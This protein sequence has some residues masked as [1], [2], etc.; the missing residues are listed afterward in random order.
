[1]PQSAPF[2]RTNVLGVPVA[3]CSVEAVAQQV[4]DW[5]GSLPSDFGVRYV[6]ATS[7]HGV[8]EAQ[9]D[10]GFMGILSR[11]SIVTPDG[12]P[13]AWMGRLQGFMGMRRVYGPDVMLEVCRLAAGRGLRH[14][15]YGGAPGVADALARR[16]C[17]QF[18]GLTVAGT[19]CPPFRELSDH[20][21]SRVAESI[22]SASTDILWVGLSTPKQERW[23][24]RIQKLLSVKVALTVGAAFDF[25]TGRVPQAPPWMQSRGLE[26]LYRVLREPRRLWRRYAYNN[27]RFLWL[28]LLQLAGLRKDTIVGD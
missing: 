19:Y 4:V 6:C 2:P 26:W 27:P 5:A 8:I 23:I 16:M 7:V 17:E 18:P 12:M 9:R 1:M 3:V 22:N 11:A 20:E 10:P 14:Y 13:L 28:S 15:F 25:H 21:I 24:A